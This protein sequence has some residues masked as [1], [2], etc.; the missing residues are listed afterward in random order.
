MTTRTEH[1]DWLVANMTSADLRGL[2]ARRWG[3]QN[4]GVSG[5]RSA[6]IKGMPVDGGELDS[7]AANLTSEDMRR[8]EAE[9]WFA[10]NPKLRGR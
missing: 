3:A 1:L 9:R 6:T 10:Q 8:I 4:G 7:L 5:D 2:E